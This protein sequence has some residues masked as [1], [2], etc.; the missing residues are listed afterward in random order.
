MRLRTSSTP[1][2]SAADL[3]AMVRSKL[4][5]TWP[6]RVAMPLLMTTLTSAL[7]PSKSFSGAASAEPATKTEARIVVAIAFFMLFTLS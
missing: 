6:V 3:A 2:S 5:S 4:D 7:D 1:S